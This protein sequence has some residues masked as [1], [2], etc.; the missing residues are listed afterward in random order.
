MPRVDPGF[1]VHKL[2]VDP[3]FPPKKQK[4]RRSIKE[5]VEVV[6]QEVKGGRGDKGNFL[7]EVVCKYCGGEE[8]ERQ[9]EVLRRFH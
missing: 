1:I 4:S 7:S 2:N 9:M 6:K 8:K 3:L 5:H